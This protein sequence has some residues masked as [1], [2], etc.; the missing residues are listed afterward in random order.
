VA[1]GY[2]ALDSRRS[3]QCQACSKVAGALRRQCCGLSVPF[4]SR[5]RLGSA[6]GVTPI[7][8]QSLWLWEGRCQVFGNLFFRFAKACSKAK[9]NELRHRPTQR[10]SPPW[11]WPPYALAVLT[12][13]QSSQAQPPYALAVLTALQS[14]QAQPP[15]ALAVL[16]ALQSSW[17]PR[18]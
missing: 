6:K 13:L 7:I 16:T 1:G 5:W 3:S 11:A 18:L 10:C 14:S 12:I 4:L 15:Y 9:S 2:L 17:A 8:Q